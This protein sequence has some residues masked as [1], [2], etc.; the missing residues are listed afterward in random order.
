[1]ARERES[2]C[3]CVYARNEEE[4][5]DRRGW[6]VKAAM[7]ENNHSLGPEIIWKPRWVEKLDRQRRSKTSLASFFYKAFPYLLAGFV[8][9]RRDSII[10]LYCP[11]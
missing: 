10:L 2:V 5:R 4:D 7:S 8:D 3:G 1:M 6:R 11:F 9:H